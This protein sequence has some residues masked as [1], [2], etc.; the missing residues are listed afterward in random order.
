MARRLQG[1]E[2]RYTRGR[3]QLVEALEAAARPATAAELIASRPPMPQ[4][5]AY[6][7]LAILAQAGVVQRVAGNDEYARYELAEELTGSH[8][9]HLICSHC[10]SVEDFTAP[11]RFERAI[12]SLID[13]IT[14]TTGFHTH[15]HNIDLLGICARCSG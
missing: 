13:A 6:R 7:N 10:G 9:H 8:H 1:I 5:T 11:A 3:R 14:E 15:S 2:Q 12:P 4:S